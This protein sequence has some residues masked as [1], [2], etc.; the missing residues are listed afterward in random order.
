MEVEEEAEA[1]GE[2]RGGAEDNKV[3]EEDGLWYPNHEMS[4]M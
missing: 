1:Q 2:V 3:G 4:G